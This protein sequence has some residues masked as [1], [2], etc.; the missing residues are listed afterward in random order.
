MSPPLSADVQIAISIAAIVL[1]VF[2]LG[3]LLL[4]RVPRSESGRMLPDDRL[5]NF[6]NRLG[7][8][9]RRLGRTEELVKQTDH[10]VRNMRASMQLL[11]TKDSV[12][13]VKVKIGELSGDVKSL[14]KTVSQ[15]HVLVGRIEGFLMDAAAKRIAGL[16]G[17]KET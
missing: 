13:E 2:A 11:A 3:A 12:S 7:T 15:T 16:D 17:G 8:V 10:D 4:R 9:E 5:Q 6:E 14:D 1:S